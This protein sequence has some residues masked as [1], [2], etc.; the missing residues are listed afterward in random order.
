[1]SWFKTA[2]ARASWLILPAVI[3]LVVTGCS[4]VDKIRGDTESGAAEVRPA[5]ETGST[6]KT[7]PNTVK[8]G[9][10]IPPPALGVDL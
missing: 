6:L 10:T 3:P 9:R 8:S 1:M 2:T 5:G 4:T 7:D